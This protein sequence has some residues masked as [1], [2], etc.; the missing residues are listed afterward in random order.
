MHMYMVP[1]KYAGVYEQQHVHIKHPHHST[2]KA[3]NSIAFHQFH[4]SISTCDIQIAWQW[5]PQT[6]CQ[7]K[8]NEK[9]W[10]AQVLETAARHL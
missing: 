9:F 10:A 5:E 3:N 8:Q 1:G 7:N 6:T 4:N 2:N